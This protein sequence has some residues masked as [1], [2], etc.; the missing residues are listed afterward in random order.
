[1]VLKEKR[2]PP[3]IKNALKALKQAGKAQAASDFLIVG[4][5]AS[6]GGL[7]VLSTFFSM[8]AHDSNM[9]FVII[10][11]L[12]PKH[13]SIMASLLEKHTKMVVVQISDGQ[14]IEP[15]HVYINPPGKNVAI[16]N[17]SLHLME[18]VET[19]SINMPIDFFFR[20]LSE[21]QKERAVGIILSGTASDGTLGIQS[22][23]AENGM[24]M[25][26]KPDTAEFDDMP[27]NAIGTGMVDLIL[28]VDKMPEALIKYAEY[29]FLE[30]QG[31]VKLMNGTIKNQLE[32]IFALVRST[33]GHDFFYYKSAS[34]SRRIECRMAVHHIKKVSDYVIFLQ[35]NKDEVGELFKNLVIGVTSFFRNPQAYKLLEQEVL[36]NL[37]KNK[38]PDSVVRIWVAGC[39]TG[40]EA[41]SFAIII[42]ELMDKLKR[43][44]RVQ[45]F[46]TDIDPV[47][48]ECAR[49]GTYP[50]NIGANISQERL[51]QF[52]T[53]TSDGFQIKKQIR[54]MVVFSIQNVI[55]DPPFSRLD[56]VSCR[57]LM[58]YMD[59]V[60]QKKIIPVFHRSLHPEG[61][62]FLGTTESIGIYKDLFTPVDTKWKIFKQNPSPSV[63]QTTYPNSPDY[64]VQLKIGAEKKDGRSVTKNLQAMVETEVIDGFNPVGILIN[65]KYDVIHFIGNTDKYLVSPT[66]KSSINVIDMVREDL[67]NSLMLTIQ[68]SIIE[69]KSVFCK[70][71][72]IDYNN[73]S[74]SVDISV[75]PITDRDGLSGFCLVLFEDKLLFDLS[76]GKKSKPGKIS[77]KNTAFQDLEHELK[78]TRE[79]LQATIEE[80]ETSNE[81]LQSTNEELLTVN[82]EIQT[83]NDEYSKVSNEM[84]NLLSAT[85]IACIFLDT[86]LCILNFTPVATEIVNLIETDIGRPLDDL[87][88]NFTGADLISLA[89]KVL[90][91]LNTIKM[92]I[93]SNDGIWYSLKIMPYRT[94]ANII[95]GI[96]MTFVDVTKLKQMDTFK[97]LATV[98]ADSNDAVSVVDLEGNILAWNKGAHQMYGWTESEALGMNIRQL[99]IEDTS[100]E[101]KW[102]AELLKKDPIKSFQTRRKLKNGKIIEVWVTITGLINEISQAME[103][104]LTERDLAWLKQAESRR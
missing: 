101:L 77:K 41:Y 86:H 64:P 39:S 89:G 94:V 70:G 88:T 54:K 48:I 78:S 99:S 49:R 15:N 30:S 98:L 25:V 1:M 65:N 96:V 6:S 26:Q 32:K 93:L 59:S 7:R 71:A 8:M 53:K 20:S 19:R 33:T 42:S 87:N 38:P 56:L 18:P 100:Y 62:L 2:F 63:R 58:I 52:F 16:F 40:E 17:R 24:V 91:D 28:P 12:S 73:H 102:F 92:D 81:E 21:D 44:F 50:E 43:Y 45:I 83:T 4:M 82:T 37:L 84:K 97:R 66:G 75:K 31:K 79:C 90:N 29:P 27:K 76:D 61:I 23:K 51:S 60:L 68:K 47:A 35:K 34:I 85:D 69:N 14:K 36:L 74:Y 13:K 22:I 9:A 5:G 10:Q 3:V 55:Q 72:E 46:A 104:A 57:N 11:H 95:A 103:F 80:L 67:K